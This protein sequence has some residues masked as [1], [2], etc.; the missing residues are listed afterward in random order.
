M[1]PSRNVPTS[2]AVGWVPA[3]AT[4]KLAQGAQFSTGVD[5]RP[6]R[7]EARKPHVIVDAW[8]IF[9]YQDPLISGRR[10]SSRFLLP[11]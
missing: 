3:P 10:H 1:I 5:I 4:T 9:D 7:E 8:P 6:S 2:G 11:L